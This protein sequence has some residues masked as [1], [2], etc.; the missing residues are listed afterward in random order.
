[1]KRHFTLIELLVVIAII[2]ILASM[3][4]PAL[5]KA[6]AAAQSA[7]CISNLKQHGL[8]VA[9][10]AGDNNETM[11][12]ALI[13]PYGTAWWSVLI[14]YVAS[15][16]GGSLENHLDGRSKVFS[17]PS[18]NGNDSIY[19]ALNDSTANYAY[20]GRAGWMAEFGVK[21]S[22]VNNSSSRMLIAD[23]NERYDATKN[24]DGS[25]ATPYYFSTIH[26]THA[27]T[28][29]LLPEEVHSRKL[30]TVYVDGHVAAVEHKSI[31]MKN[32]DIRGD[33]E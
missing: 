21:I 26:V 30:N 11:P 1:M 19:F 5:S 23:G 15:D 18:I 13:A 28:L 7:K 3:L 8:A 20:N 16:K 25:P 10:Y 29:S 22:S 31:E 27:T 33:W 12:G 24:T 14:P 6:R 4:L 32:V 2:A 9:M 17:C